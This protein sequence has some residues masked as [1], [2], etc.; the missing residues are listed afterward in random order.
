MTCPQRPAF[1]P[2]MIERLR[3]DGLPCLIYDGA[4]PGLA[5]R[6][7]ENSVIYSYY[8][9][10]KFHGAKRWLQLGGVSDINLE[11]ARKAA[12]VARGRVLD[13]EDP[14][15][16]RKTAKAEKKVAVAAVKVAMTKT[17]NAM[18]DDFELKG[19]PH[20]KPRSRTEYKRLFDK[21]IRDALGSKLAAEIT[22]GDVADLHRALADKPVE[23]NRTVAV[24]SSAY[25]WA[26]DEEWSDDIANPCR[27]LKKNKETS[28]ETF[29]AADQ[30]ATAEALLDAEP[31]VRKYEVACMRFILMTGTR[32]TEARK[33]KWSEVDIGRCRAILEEHKTDG[34]IGRKTVTFPQQIA[35]LLRELEAI[36]KADSDVVFD[37]IGTSKCGADKDGYIPERRIARCWERIRTAMGM[38]HVRI[39][40]LRHSYISLAISEHVDIAVVSKAVGHANINTTMKY[41][42][43]LDA[44]R[45]DA[46]VSV[47][48]AIAAKRKPK[49]EVGT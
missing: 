31:A 33:L 9:V 22:R 43:L 44:Q 15:G 48:A 19:F 21:R 45:D 38:P 23:A 20:L 41:V 3:V 7:R 12:I 13:G 26:E 24:L 49:A 16:E 36:R 47:H 4:T 37:P 28:K 32:H 46:A 27:R 30:L 39:H 5:I 35:D 14:A 17:L 25:T 18:L 11:D 6:C 40:D 2:K 29:L 42:H 8:Y 1:T 10:Y 34:T